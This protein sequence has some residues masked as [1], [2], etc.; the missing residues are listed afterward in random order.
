MS[1]YKVINR[2]KE[3]NHDDHVYEIGD[4]Y[5]AVGKKLVKTRADFLTKSHATYGVAFLKEV[6]SPIPPKKAPTKA[7]TK[8]QE[9]TDV[10]QTS[11][12]Q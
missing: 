8:K 12:D 9:M 4:D 5:P 11:D 10:E 6:E 1:Q 7:T 3:K 2:F